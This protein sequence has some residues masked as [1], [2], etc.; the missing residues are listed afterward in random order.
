[1]TSWNRILAAAVFIFVVA[2]G[3]IFGRA[4]L[5]FSTSRG[6]AHAAQ[7]ISRPDYSVM[8]AH[9]TVDRWGLQSAEPFLNPSTVPYVQR[10]ARIDVDGVVTAQP[11]LVHG[12]LVNGTVQDALI[13]VTSGAPCCPNSGINC[14]CKGGQPTIYVL[15]PA[16]LAPI[17]AAISVPATSLCDA[18]YCTGVLSTPVIDPLTAFLYLVSIDSGGAVPVYKLFA[19]DLNALTSPPTATTIAGECAPGPNG[20]LFQANNGTSLQQGQRPALLLYDHHI[21]I[22]FGAHGDEGQKYNGW[23]FAYTTMDSTNPLS[24]VAL[25]ADG[26]PA[27]YCVSRTNPQSPVGRGGIWQLGAG[28][29]VDNAGNIYAAT[30]N[31]VTSGQGDANNDADSYI[32]LDGANWTGQLKSKSTDPDASF[33]ADA[34]LDI[35]STGLVVLP[36]PNGTQRLMGAGKRGIVAFLNPSQLSNNATRFRGAWHQFVPM[37]G[38]K[39]NLL[40]DEVSYDS[41]ICGGPASI[42]G[43]GPNICCTSDSPCPQIHGSMPHIH[44]QPCFLPNAAQTGGQ[45]FWWGEKDFPRQLPWSSTQGCPTD[46]SNNCISGLSKLSNRVS[47]DSSDAAPS[48]AN[49]PDRFYVRAMPGAMMSLSANGKSGAVL[50]ANV[51]QDASY[52]PGPAWLKAFDVSTFP[53]THIA[54]ID[55]GIGENHG[56]PTIANGYVYV[57]GQ[58]DTTSRKG[59]ISAYSANAPNTPSWVSLPGLVKSVGS[60]WVI[61]TNPVGPSD[62]GITQWVPTAANGNPTTGAWRTGVPGG[63]VTISVDLTGT[64]WVINSAHQI[65]QWSGSNWTPYA[66]GFCATSVASGTN[67]TETWAIDCSNNLWH[68]DGS[69]AKGQVPGGGTKV[70]MLSR[71]DLT[72]GDRLPIIIGEDGQLYLYYHPQG[73]CGTYTYSLPQGATSDISTDFEVGGTDGSLYRFDP[74]RSTSTSSVWSSY[75][76]TPWGTN[77]RIGAW[78]EGI[79]AM[80][81]V[82]GSIDMLKAN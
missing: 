10:V 52:P 40:Q 3:A 33:L 79:F 19:Y 74:V 82:S 36:G 66:S 38:N 65:F 14:P 71:I 2:L 43:Q 13:V 55:L 60:G 1:M 45:L 67:A 15:N 81:S 62:F 34:D 47:T 29:S 77:T 61:G 12:R 51:P 75:T 27:A 6:V 39:T 25:L 70:A 76:S 69:G 32:Q 26:Q 58:T 22:A 17:V 59:R 8:T 16:T 57:A 49:V 50:W 30:G 42:P 78:S 18:E 44:G 54:Q 80:D 21:Y 46:S 24:P 53:K 11:L 56:Y 23:I 35:A 72:C 7:L 63:A 48:N 37:L 20:E 28:L 68:F 5:P 64:P 4:F 31:G 73:L 9:N 41:A